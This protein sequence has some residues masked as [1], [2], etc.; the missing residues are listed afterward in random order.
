MIT[1]KKP[2]NYPARRFKEGD[3]IEAGADLAPHISTS[4]QEGGFRRAPASK[5]KDAATNPDPNHA[6]G[7]RGALPWRA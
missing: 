2:F 7:R 1:V 6:G 3:K 4:L 5:A